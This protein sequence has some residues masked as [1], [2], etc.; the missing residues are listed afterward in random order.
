MYELFNHSTNATGVEVILDAVDPNGNYVHLGTATSNSSGNFGFEWQT[1]D[2]PGKY[3]IIATFVGSDYPSFSETYAVV[4]NSPA[5]T[6]EPTPLAESIADTYFIPAIAGIIVVIVI[7]FA[8]MALLF[9]R[10]RP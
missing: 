1:P 4:R 8:I 2:V 7:G 6:S 10:K 9:L 5:V 3:N